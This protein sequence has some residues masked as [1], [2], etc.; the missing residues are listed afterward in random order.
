MPDQPRVIIVGGGLASLAAAIRIAVASTLVDQFFMVPVKRSHSVCAQGGIN[1]CNKVA[2]QQGYTCTVIRTE[3][4]MPQAY[5]VLEKLNVQYRDL[6]LSDSG[7]WTN[8]NLS[9]ARAVGDMIIYAEAILAAALERKES[10]S[11]HYRPD[12]PQRDDES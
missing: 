10:R 8:Q 7:L 12:Y 9:F 6:K 3:Q 4:R 5:E 1:A 2:R 11:R